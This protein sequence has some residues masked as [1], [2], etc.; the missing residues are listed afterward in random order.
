MD[1]QSVEEIYKFRIKTFEQNVIRLQKTENRIVV[2]R[3]LTFFGAI[4]LFIFIAG[5]NM[6]LATALAVAGL[7]IFTVLIKYNLTISKQKQYYQHLK[8][9][10]L[11]ETECLNG[12]FSIFPDGKEYLNSEH[13]YTGDL[14][15]FGKAS[16]FQL[17]NRT[18]SEPGNE[19]LAAWLENPADIDEILLRQEAIKELSHKVDF[20]QNLLAVGYEH[21]KAKSLNENIINWAK[22][23]PLFAH[24][25]FI[26][27]FIDLLS[28]IIVSVVV[29]LFFGLS[30]VYLTIAII[31]N[32]FAAGWFN[33]K[34]NKI[35][36]E[37]SNTVGWLM[38]YSSIIELTEKETF[39]SQKLKELQLRFTG[40]ENGASG[41][42]K[43]ISGL[44]NKL[45]YR[46]NI[47]AGFVL[48][49]LLIWDIRIVLQLE[50]WKNKNRTF[51][52]QWFD[53]MAEFEA[54]SSL[55]TLKFNNPVWVYPVLSSDYF[56][57][58]AEE[59]GHPLIT[60]KKELPT[61]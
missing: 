20:R 60:E 24:F 12:N 42:L 8:E 25:K 14:D 28:I 2:Y 37:V 27:P 51:I 47:I 3:V 9:I 17:L 4:V 30:P 44:V 41:Q 52:I 11:H 34:I 10:N 23:E 59:L 40:T 61:I 13:P 15:I 16:L 49:L 36:R 7:G 19:K 32:L 38:A 54:L 5:Y 55:A 57:F 29:L 31:I 58:K 26:K 33:K 21:P 43:I 39:S 22:Q 50:R 1:H 48:N 35:H 53:A 56:R 18:T 46:L 45:D 6:P